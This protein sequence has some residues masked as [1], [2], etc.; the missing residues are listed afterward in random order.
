MTR[1]RLANKSTILPR[2]LCVHFFSRPN[3]SLYLRKSLL[4]KHNTNI[5]KKKHLF[6]CNIIFY[7]SFYFQS[8]FLLFL[9]CVFTMRMRFR[10]GICGDRKYVCVCALLHDVS[11]WWFRVNWKMFKMQRNIWCGCAESFR[12]AAARRQTRCKCNVFVAAASARNALVKL[13]VRQPRRRAAC[14]KKQYLLQH[15]AVMFLFQ[16]RGEYFIYTYI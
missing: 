2:S 12:L 8:N 3:N 1:S 9:T 15:Y 13:R 7:F 16:L 4:Y 5:R 10:N 14:I 11:R 6:T